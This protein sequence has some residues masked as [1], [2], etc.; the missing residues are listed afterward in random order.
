MGRT[1]PISLRYCLLTQP[2]ES[3]EE[4]EAAEE[5]AEEEEPAEVLTLHPGCP[6]PRTLHPERPQPVPQLMRSLLR[7]RSLRWNP[8]P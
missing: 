6:A 2:A 4:E 8:Q 1:P 7:R 5:P 3:A